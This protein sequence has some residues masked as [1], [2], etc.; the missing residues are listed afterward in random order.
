MDG[1]LPIKSSASI[2]KSQSSSRK[3]STTPVTVGD[4][5]VEKRR[6]NNIAAAKYR[7]KKVDRIEEL[8]GQLRA[9]TSERDD[10]KIAL[11]K[12]DAEVELPCIRIFR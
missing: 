7:Q 9:M 3:R 11:A 2:T 6:R 5:R 1:E 12:R 10:L 8:E 4:D